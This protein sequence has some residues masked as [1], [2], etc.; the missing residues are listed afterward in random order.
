MFSITKL[1]KFFVILITFL[2]VTTYATYADTIEQFEYGIV[3][4]PDSQCI[5]NIALKNSDENHIINDPLIL[6]QNRHISL[7][8]ANFKTKDISNIKKQLSI[9]APKPFFIQVESKYSK[10]GILMGLNIH[11]TNKLQE[12]H[13]DVVKKFKNYHQKPLKRAK[14]MYHL[15]SLEKQKQIDEFGTTNILQFYNPKITLF[16]Q[17]PITKKLQ[18]AKLITEPIEDNNRC[19]VSVLAVAKLKDDGNIQ[20]IVE[21]IKL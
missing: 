11:N 3:L 18:D 17:Y 19:T 7:Y 9:L 14:E 12:L 10:A 1:Y 13:E 21:M 8:Q 5:K 20:E 15:L 4:L 6:E 16:Y 2:F